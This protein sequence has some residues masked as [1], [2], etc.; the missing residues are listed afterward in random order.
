[1]RKVLSRILYALIA[2]LSLLRRSKKEVR[3]LRFKTQIAEK[4]FRLGPTKTVIA[5]A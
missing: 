1:M 3:T 5:S 4:F 2:K